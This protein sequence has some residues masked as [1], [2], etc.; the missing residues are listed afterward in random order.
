MTTA[1][2]LLQ[3][4]DVEMASTRRVLTRISDDKPNYKPHEKSMA[5]GRLAMHVA[6]LPLFGKTILTTPSM[7]LAN[8]NQKW[9]D[10]TFVSRDR[11]LAAFDENAAAA[12]AALAAASDAD[13]AAN[14]KFSFGD[15]VISDGPRSL[16][17]RHMFFNHLI[18]HRAQL[19]VYL[20]LNDIPVPGLYGP[21]ADEPFNPG[22]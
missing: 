20:R 16:A 3:D 21:S 10:M 14:W 8:P 9:P 12:R 15:H 11:L 13:L 7:D 22:K 6:T 18:H 2:L 17:Y 1:E 4:F 19:G 5:M